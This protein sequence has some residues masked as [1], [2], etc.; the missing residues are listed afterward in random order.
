MN[1][2]NQTS[3]T[4]ILKGAFAGNA[5][6]GK[7]TVAAA[8]T[9]S[10]PGSGGGEVGLTP[11]VADII[12]SLVINGDISRLSAAQKV[13][14]YKQFCDKLGLDPMS[15]PFRILRLHGREI[16]Y[17]DRGGAQQLNKLHR[18]SHRIKARETVNNCYVVT[19]Q[20]STLDGRTTESIGAV[21]IGNLKGE[22]LCNAMMKAETKAKRR[23]TLDLLGLGLL[24]ETEVPPPGKDVEYADVNLN[25]HEG[26]P[27]SAGGCGDG[28]GIPTSLF[29]SLKG[30]EREVAQCKNEEELLALYNDNRHR[31]DDN[32]AMLQCF[33][34]RKNEL[35]K[36]AA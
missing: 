15:Q 35:R 30:L 34:R 14:Y 20:A 27:A 6:N 1:T 26:L 23:A 4:A 8:E 12:T 29:L 32:P 22:S 25:D 7:T 5:I 24:D 9:R 36:N 31:V 16:L 11:L 10:M 18:L 19:A 33:T 13:S 17:C 28:A 3:Q 2:I 21:N